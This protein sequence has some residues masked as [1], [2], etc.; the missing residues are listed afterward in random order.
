MLLCT[1]LGMSANNI[2]E[3][4][5]ATCSASSGAVGPWSFQGGFSV[6]ASDASKTYQAANGGI[7]YSAG[8]QYTITLPEGVS[9]KHVEIYGYDNYA[10]VDS[11]LGELNGKEYSATAIVFPQKTAD[12]STVPVTRSVTLVEAATGTLTFTPQGKQV[13]WTLRLYDY[14]PADVPADDLT[15]GRNNN[16]FYTPVSQ[17][18]KIDRAPVALPASS[19][20]GIFLSWR[21]L[22]TDD[23]QTKFDIVRDGSTIKR[24]LTVST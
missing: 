16:L 4:S 13:V 7:K 5:A 21:F 11:Y 9:V 8:L 3:L 15:Q 19:G 24:D 14:N 20:K 12:G 2:Y 22:G 17:M 23:L 1:S 6:M 10:D 18:E